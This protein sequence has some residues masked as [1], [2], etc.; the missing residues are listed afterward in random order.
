VA[1]EYKWFR[2]LENPV[3]SIDCALLI[4]S[5]YYSWPWWKKFSPSVAKTR[6]KLMFCFWRGFG[7]HLQDSFE[8]NI[9][10]RAAVSLRSKGDN[11]DRRFCF[12]G[13][14]MMSFMLCCFLVC[15][16]ESTRWTKEQ[17]SIRR[18]L[19]ENDALKNW[20]WLRPWR[21]SVASGERA[22]GHLS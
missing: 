15:R 19:F 16:F 20:L 4:A 1:K 21:R 17:T 3:V 22:S 5:F 6:K 11:L 8:A 10:N 14:F 2:A 9:P 12:V 18:L 7:K 13:S